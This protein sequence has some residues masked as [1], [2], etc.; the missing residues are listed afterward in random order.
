[1]RTVTATANANSMVNGST[2]RP[3][4]SVI[5]VFVNTLDLKSLGFKNVDPSI[6]A[7]PGYH[8]ATMLKLYIYGYLKP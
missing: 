5:D 3:R 7:R 1:M 2:I 8:P 6:T 4:H